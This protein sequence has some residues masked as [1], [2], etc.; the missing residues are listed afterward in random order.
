MRNNHNDRRNA[1]LQILIQPNIGLESDARHSVVEILNIGLANEAVL[2][3]KTRSAHWNVSGASFFEL[4]NL[5]DSQYVQLNKISDEIA[6]RAR[7]LGGLPIGSFEGFLKNT[8]L[9]EQ[10]G[11]VPEIMDLLADHE[12]V[13]RFLREDAKKCSEEYEDEGTRDF[14][15]NILFLHEKMA[16][17][18]RSHIEPELTGS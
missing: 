17:V 15:V 16:W 12:A 2:T 6:E 18:L 4:Q 1:K 5:F 10:P 11:N 7:M 8:R 3:L 13:I 9:E 14:L